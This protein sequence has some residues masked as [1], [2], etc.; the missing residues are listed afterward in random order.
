MP[1]SVSPCYLTVLERE[2]LSSQEVRQLLLS[3]SMNGQ[4]N[5]ESIK[6]I[7]FQFGEL[8]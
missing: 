6:P 4:L 7:L 3:V 1:L 2:P 5:L 8:A